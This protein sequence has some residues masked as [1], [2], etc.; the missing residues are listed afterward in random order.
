L[1]GTWHFKVEYQSVGFYICTGHDPTI[2]EVNRTKIYGFVELFS[3]LL[4]IVLYTRI[5]FYKN[6]GN[7]LFNAPSVT[8]KLNFLKEFE[9]QS[10]TT[11]A[12]HF[13]GIF[14][15]CASTYNTIQISGVKAKDFS[16]YPNYLFVYYRSL[17][18]SSTAILGVALIF[19]IRKDYLRPFVEEVK[20][21]NCPNNF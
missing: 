9:T 11:F 16:N 1:E 2:A 20:E 10:L 7:I 6:K 19:F 5:Y 18:S 21:L 15:L 12:T 8:L 14:V 17:V 13:F 4:H 3:A